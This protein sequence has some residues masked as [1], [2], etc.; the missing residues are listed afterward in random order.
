MKLTVSKLRALIRESILTEGIKDVV[1]QVSDELNSA[2][3]QNH[4]MSKRPQRW[5]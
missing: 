5:S 3:L 4:V 2:G 1:Q